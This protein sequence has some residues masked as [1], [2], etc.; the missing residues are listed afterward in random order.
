[1]WSFLLRYLEK[2]NNPALVI[3]LFLVVRTYRVQKQVHKT[4]TVLN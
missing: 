4:F 3:F 1:M 2:R